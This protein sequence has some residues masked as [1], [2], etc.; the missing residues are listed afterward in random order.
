[1]G[2]LLDTSPSSG[3]GMGTPYI[4]RDIFG[5]VIDSPKT[6]VSGTTYNPGRCSEYYMGPSSADTTLVGAVQKTLVFRWRLEQSYIQSLNMLINIQ[7][8]NS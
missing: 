7:N 8:G 6:V 3:P 2:T 5:N 4:T 1:M